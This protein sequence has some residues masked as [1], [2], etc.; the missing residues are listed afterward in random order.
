MTKYGIDESH[1]MIK[2]LLAMEKRSIGWADRVLTPNLAF[3]SL[4]V[5]R[6]NPAE[7]IEIIMNTPLE[8]LFLDCPCEPRYDPGEDLKIIYHGSIVV[9]HG[10]TDALDAVEILLPEMPG[11]RFDIYGGGDFVQGLQEE[12]SDRGL[13]RNVVFHGFMDQDALVHEI[14]K[15]DLGIIPNRR[16]PFTEVNLPTRIFEYLCLGKP[17][18]VPETRGIA[19]YF[20]AESLL[21]FESGNARDLANRIGAAYK[22]PHGVRETIRRGVEVY[23]RHTWSGQRQRLIEIV[24]GLLD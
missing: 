5:S 3:R 24:S 15:A 21:Y 4:F 16:T 13:S 9:R 14:V 20:D 2:V 7:K 19:D 12:I 11:L 18:I 23:R 10:L 17:V 1:R 22:D 8:T 6:G